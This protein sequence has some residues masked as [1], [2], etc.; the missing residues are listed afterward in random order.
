M[1]STL[2]TFNPAPEVRVGGSTPPG[3]AELL[4]AATVEESVTG[5]ARAEVRLDNW[6]ATAAG[7]GYVFED[8]SVIDFGA[9]VD[10]AF[11]PPDERATL[12]TGRIT[13]IEGSFGADGGPTLVLLA[14]DALQDLRMT[15]RTRTFEDRTDAEVIEEVANDH[16]LTP[17]VDLDGPA[18]PAICQLNQS[19]LAFVRDRALPYGADVWLDG[20]TLHVGARDDDAIVLRHGRELLS[21]RVLADLAQQATEQRVAGWDPVAKEAV[22]ETADQSS[23][24]AA[25]GRDVG[26]GSLLADSFDDRPATTT[27]HRAVTP[28]EATAIARGLYRQRARRFVTGSGVSDGI[29]GLR[30]GRSVELS[31]YGTL[32]DGTY[33]LDRV[34]HRYDRGAGYRTEI[35]VERSG[36]GA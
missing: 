19:D 8:R 1:P 27:L 31:G 10:L 9:T 22:L 13:G 17:A 21:L 34:V 29:V 4:V 35:D 23:L 11:G 28:A 25:L 3:V 32:F 24:G 7:P 26:G 2:T 33:R 5:L 15:R 36:L 6:G 12:F 18:L 20:R 30:A 14:E 16:G